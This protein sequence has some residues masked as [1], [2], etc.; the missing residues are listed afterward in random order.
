MID[1]IKDKI[2]ELEKQKS[3]YYEMIEKGSLYFEESY[4]LNQIKICR[5]KIN[6]LEEV[7]DEIKQRYAKITE[8]IMNNSKNEDYKGLI[9]N[10]K[11]NK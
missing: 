10:D 5:A 1:I 3:D 11:I 9:N 6:I 2:K 7:I 8:E 4:I